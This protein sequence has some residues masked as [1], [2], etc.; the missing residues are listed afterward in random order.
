MAESQDT[1]QDYEKALK[2]GTL[3]NFKSNT[4]KIQPQGM[5]ASNT[6]VP[7]KTQR[8]HPSKI[9]EDVVLILILMSSI[10]LAVD[11]PLKDPNS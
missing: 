5:F 8:K 9:F 10:L 1:L 3:E 2:E 11:N 6:K 7:K 4:M